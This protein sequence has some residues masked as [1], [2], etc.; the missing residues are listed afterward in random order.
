[1]FREW[2]F[3]LLEI[4]MLLAAAALL[5]LVVG[6]VIWGG[7][8]RR[9]REEIRTLHSSR[10]RKMDRIEGLESDIRALKSRYNEGLLRTE[11]KLTER[12]AALQTIEERLATIDDDHEKD[13]DALRAA[14]ADRDSR[15]LDM[16]T[17]MHATPDD[18]SARIA[19]L[20]ADLKARDQ[21][22]ATLSIRANDKASTSAPIGNG[23]GNGFGRTPMMNDAG[24]L[25]RDAV[26]DAPAAALA[27]STAPFVHHMD[28]DPD[29]EAPIRPPG[30]PVARGGFPD[31]LTQIRGI[32][33]SLQDLCNDLGIFHFDQ[34]AKW[35]PAEVAWVDENLD[36]FKG[37]ATR[38]NWVEQAAKLAETNKP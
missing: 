21:E 14:V 4:W 35:S 18:A 3:L 27:E 28:D 8:L 38:D 26:A 17:K 25:V 7:K 29:E 23:T 13:I 5:G 16:E 12:E 31:D 11:Q 1:M 20:E 9:A 15:I 2:D 30:F 37:R 6:G 33:P 19:E 24:A 36:G 32:G 10:E 34:I 22:I